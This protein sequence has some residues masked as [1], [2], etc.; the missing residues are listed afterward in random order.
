MSEQGSQAVQVVEGDSLP[1]KVDQRIVESKR[2]E[3]VQNWSGTLTSKMAYQMARISIAYGLDPFLGELVVLGDKPYPT[4]SA[5]QR[6]A[7]EDSDFDGEICRPA[8]TQERTDFYFPHEPPDDEYLWR[9]EVFLKN[10]KLPFVGWGRASKANVKM[11]TMQLW[12][13]EMA[14]KRA[15]GRTYRLAFNIGLPT[16]EEMWEFEDG[17]KFRVSEAEEIKA[18]ATPEQIEKIDSHILVQEYVT[19]GC[20]LK[21]EWDGVYESM[22]TTMTRAR[23][24]KIIEHFLGPNGVIAQRKAQKN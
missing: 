1:I 4:V 18:L 16:I 23:A 22:Q 15:R 2:L 12:L 7:N 8:T 19:A 13:P 20:I 21:S 14:Q 3:I 5:L 11:S 6:K 17:E 24:E 9:C 10:R